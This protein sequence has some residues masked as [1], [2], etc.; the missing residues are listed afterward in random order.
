MCSMKRFIL[1]ATVALLVV[2]SFARFAAPVARAVFED[3]EIVTRGEWGAN[4]DYLLP[5]PSSGGDSQTGTA[6]SS[7]RQ[8]CEDLQK[9]VPAEFKT[10]G[11]KIGVDAEGRELW[12][13][14]TYSSE[15]YKIVIHETA[16]DNG[17]DINGDG[18]KNEADAAATV[19]G[20]YFNHAI[21]RGWGDL[22]YNFLID[23]FGNIYE[24]RAGG[25]GVVGA[26]A[27]CAN[28]GT[29][30]IA[31]I[32][33]F[34]DVPPMDAAMDAATRLL[35]ELAELYNLNLTARSDWHG[36]N[37]PNLVGHSDYGATLD[38]LP[39]L[40]N[41]MLDLA[42]RAMAYARGLANQDADFAYRILESDS[43]AYLTPLEER[44][45]SIQLKNTGKKAWPQN[46]LFRVARADIRKNKK[47]ASL[48]A[49]AEFV[50]RLDQRVNAGATVTLQIPVAAKMIAGRYR[51][52]ITPS[53]GENLRKFYL[54]VNV[55]EPQLDYELVDAKHP[56][57]P[58]A[59]NAAAVAW[60][61]LKNNSNFVWKKSGEHR[62]Y[63]GTTKPEKRASP[64]LTEASDELASLDVDTPPGSTARF[65][66][67]LTAPERAGRYQI[68]FAPAI[69][70]FGYLP[71]YG[72]QFHTTVREPRFTAEVLDKSSGADLRFAPG[73]TRSLFI[74]LQNTSQLV[75]NP[76][77]FELNILQAGG[78]AFDSDAIK[79]SREIGEGERARI[80]FEL[81]APVR[82]GKYR[83][84]LQP[85]W[86][87]GKLK[88]AQPIDFLVEVESARLTGKLVEKPDPLELARGDSQKIVFG[89]QNTG[90][91]IWNSE[92]TILQSLPAEPSALATSDWISTVQP[93][94]LREAIVRPNETGHFEFTVQRPVD[95]GSSIESF[96][97]FVRGLGRIRGAAA[98]VQFADLPAEVIE[99]Q[100]TQKVET[101]LS[102]SANR[103]PTIRIRLSFRSDRIEIGGGEFALKNADG[104]EIF[105]GT[106]ADFE[107]VKITDGEFFRVEP[108][109]DTILEIPNWAHHPGWSDM[110]ND[111]KFR[112]VLEIRRLGDELVVIN[113]LPLEDYL[114]GVAEPLPTDPDEKVKL[115]AVLA[116]SY[117]AFYAD[118]AHRKFPGQP[119]DGSDDPAE[120]QKYI[121]YNYELRG[122]MPTAVEQT[123]GLA[124]TYE[125]A[126]VK[127]PYFTSSG[128]RTK[129]AAEARW[130][131]AD[132]AFVKAVADPWSCG[133]N[134]NAIG[135][136]FGCPASAR[137]HGVGVSGMGAAGL[138]REGRTFREIIDYFFEGV[139]VEEIY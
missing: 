101:D 25:A 69:M 31:F 5:Q 7:R 91:V 67:N 83:F 118:P 19:R 60:V 33:A 68:A 43:P 20:I 120:F 78:L 122:N 139:G 51:F 106:F 114:R 93:A 98:K 9:E 34:Q 89:Y 27:Y 99:V 54:V 18:L 80:D 135:T 128:G 75:W 21:W 111:N 57:Q 66:M 133:L 11:R 46:G 113:E 42:E 44:T 110:L 61:S 84:T 24:G 95:A 104:A 109:G 30:G 39:P 97:P 50:A 53:F 35:A 8:K 48:N 1:V 136:D 72:L 105:V 117:A 138:A 74:T 77:Q 4:P 124:V 56:P 2:V 108:R 123:R 3:L 13:P 38:P 134:S 70:N 85:R 59:P 116:R 126:V 115:L 12:W 62:V 47:G 10:D 130:N 17:K 121:G 76:D 29:V 131:A 137:G 90:N 132:F 82:A 86:Q 73:E 63:L 65:V 79:L 37:T 36:K 119:Y 81:T 100:Q 71:D 28:I 58:F 87:N 55:A 15:I 112:G 92:S 102:D 16:S 32:G 45:L 49:D 96:V 94:R 6:W 26:H 22:G 107:K 88:K 52:G 14:R 127:T 125:G 103:G 41:S 23:A 129:T 40:Y 64:F